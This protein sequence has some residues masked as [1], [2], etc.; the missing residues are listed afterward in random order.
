M[1][2]VLLLWQF[3]AWY[4]NG[5]MDLALRFPTPAESISWVWDSLVN[6]TP[7]YYEYGPTIIDHTVASLKRMLI[8]FFFAAVIGVS[9]GSL[10]GFC[11]KIYNIGIIPVIVFQSIPGLAWIPIALILFGLGDDAAVFIIFMVS[12]MVI[13]MN[14][15]SGIR[16]T[17]QVI[18]RTAGMMGANHLIMFIKILIPFAAIPI[19]NGLRLG[20]GSAWRVLIAA[21]MLIGTGIGL[22]T[23]MDLLRD[24][25]DF[26]GAFG[27]IVIICIIGLIIDRGV[28][29]VIER[30]VRH[31]LGMEEGH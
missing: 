9:V 25:L 18:V 11:S 10:I 19:I 3:L 4:C 24:N 6:G 17:P 29:A 16:M 8:A 14:V 5:Y 1:L 26:V 27:C 7:V 22:G 15:A 12:L 20:I 21:E 23:S 13:T 30:A 28:F 31:K 2:I